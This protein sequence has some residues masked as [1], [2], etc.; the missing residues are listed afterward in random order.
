[1]ILVFKIN[2]LNLEIEKV[3]V[4]ILVFLDKIVDDNGIIFVI[5]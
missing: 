2:I 3:I 5:F 1:M 4:L